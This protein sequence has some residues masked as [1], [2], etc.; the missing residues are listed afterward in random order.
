MADKSKKKGKLKKT[1]GKASKK[2]GGK[3]TSSRRLEELKKKLQ[4]V[5]KDLLKIEKD[6][7]SGLSESTIVTEDM[8]VFERE[9]HALE[10]PTD[11]SPKNTAFYKQFVFKCQKCM[12]GEFPHE[13]E[14][15][16]VEK[17]VVCPECKET[18][19][20]Y[21]TPGSRYHHIEFPKS[22]KVVKKK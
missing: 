5:D 21:I 10:K 8:R 13:A 4:K 15:P 6:L 22:L 11:K 19:T 7:V 12:K 16:V 18:H 9:L 20:Y 14:V 1:P 17:H 3:K 2:S